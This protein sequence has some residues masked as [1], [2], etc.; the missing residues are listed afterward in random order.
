[1]GERRPKEHST[2]A[3]NKRMEVRSRRLKK[4]WSILIEARTQEGLQR[5]TWMV[6]RTQRNSRSL[7]HAGSQDGETSYLKTPRKSL[8]FPH[9]AAHPTGSD[10]ISPCLDADNT[11]FESVQH[12]PFS[13]KPQLLPTLE[14]KL[15][16]MD[17]N[18]TQFW[19]SGM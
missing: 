16:R 3:R 19:S 13:H 10:G 15:W 18:Q 5:H 4:W 7:L 11:C 17:C 2:D 12:S 1:M 9:P 14:Q 8:L 6:G